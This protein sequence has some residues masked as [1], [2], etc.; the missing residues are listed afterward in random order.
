MIPRPF[1][2]FVPLVAMAVLGCLSP[3]T[4]AAPATPV[5]GGAVVIEARDR[6]RE[7]HPTGRQ[8]LRLAGTT[9][10]PAPLD[11]AVARDVNSAFMT[12]QVFRGLTRSTRT[13]SPFRSWRNV[14]RSAPMG[15]P[16]GFNSGITP[17][18]PTALKSRPRTWCSR[19]HGHSARRRR[20]TR[21]L[22]WLV[23]RTLAISSA[24]IRSFRAKRASY[25]DCGSSTIAR[26][27]LTS[28]RLGQRS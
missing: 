6:P 28:R 26:W 23:R 2:M 19:S 18:S 5:T 10:D 15:S 16:I 13:W 8:E 24:R 14:S 27:R 4:I 17:S 9:I 25:Q 3:L 20:L 7:S 11:P 22:R 21:A 12:R 1:R